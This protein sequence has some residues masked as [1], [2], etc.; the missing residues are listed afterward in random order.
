MYAGSPSHPSFM[1]LEIVPV[2]TASDLRR[3]IDVPWHVYDPQ[4]HPQWVPPLRIAVRDTLDD[5]KHPF[6]KE[7]A[8]AL[9]IARRDGK[10]VGRIAAIE[11]R[12][13]NKHYG[14]R[15]GFFG[16][17]EAK[18]DPEAAR[19]LVRFAFCK[20]DEVLAEAVERLGRLK[21]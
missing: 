2:E 4:H 12:A 10:P 20:R 14:D 17:F 1:P 3:F 16:F 18:D 13:H 11:N 9:W 6:Y 7:G 8:R 21:G 5:R 19:S 15:V